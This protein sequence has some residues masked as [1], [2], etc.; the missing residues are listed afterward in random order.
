M[1]IYFAASVRA[2]RDDGAM[3]ADII[4]LLKNYG[5]IL[6]E[7]NGDLTLTSQGD[8]SLSDEE[9]F[10]RDIVWFTSSDIIVAEVTTPSL[11]VGYEIATALSVGKPVLCLY[12]ETP[13]KRLS[14]MING[15]KRIIVKTYKNIK[16]L[17]KILEVFFKD[18]DRS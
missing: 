3:Y 15:D 13:G 6:C 1:K 11:G 10:K 12:R 5:E 16:D 14:A 7:T 18:Y 2:G 17:P 4:K 8:T 9:I